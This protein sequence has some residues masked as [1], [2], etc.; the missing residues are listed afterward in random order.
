MGTFQS[1]INNILGAAAVAAT[2]AKSSIEKSKANAQAEAEAN[3]EKIKTSIKE[4]EA[5]AKDIQD[6][7]EKLDDARQL[8]IGYTQADI[9]KSKAAKAM[10]IDLPPKNPRG[11]S[12]KTFNRRYANAQAMQVIQEKYLQDAEFRKRISNIKPKDLAAAMKPEI[13]KRGGKK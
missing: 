13:N 8:A 4:Q 6:T 2:T 5:E 11:V 9:R 10:G 3:E 12:N 1:G 7:Q